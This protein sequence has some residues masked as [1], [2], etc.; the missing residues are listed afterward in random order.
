[1]RKTRQLCSS[2]DFLS[3]VKVLFCLRG[4][5]HLAETYTK[6]EIGWALRNNVEVRVWSKYS[7]PYGFPEQCPV[8]RDISLADAAEDFHPDIIHSDLHYGIEHSLS[9]SAGIPLTV[10]GHDFGHMDEW[11]RGIADSPRVLRVFIFPHFAA[12]HSGNQKVSPMSACY[13]ETL[14]GVSVRPKDPGSVVRLAPGLPG[15]NLEGFLRIAK[16]C[17]G[18]RF[19]L[20]MVRT[21]VA[22]NEGYADR[23]IELNRTLGASVDIRVNVSHDECERL[24][25]TSSFYLHTHQGDDRAFGMPQCVSEAFASG[26]SV[27][28]PALSGAAG[29]VGKGGVTY[30]SEDEAACLIRATAQWTEAER[31]EAKRGVMERAA[32]LPSDSVLA[33]LLEVWKSCCR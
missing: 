14:Y 5:P 32:A 18:F 9:A 25:S 11:V 31:L 3:S 4:Y 19:T 28:I 29:Y 8:Y 21:Y 6:C 17:P 26:C 10:R 22:P 20:G 24:L 23:I 27:L 33:P 12:R 15:K 30:A 2:E 16:A 7:S 13:D 1:M